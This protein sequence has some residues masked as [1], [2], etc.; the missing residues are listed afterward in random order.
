M[1]LLVE[2]VK[3]IG[4]ALIVVFI[5]KE[6]LVKLLRK[7]AE[8]LD[9][10]PKAVGNIA[11]VA[12][13]MPELLTV[14]FSSLQGLLSTSIYNIFSSNLINVVQYWV[15]VMLNKN[16]KEL[17]NR[18]I[19]TELILVFITILIPAVMVMFEFETNII[20]VPV[21]ICAFALFYKVRANAYKVYNT[22]EIR[23]EEVKK[24]TEE[25]RWI[26]HK[27]K[28]EVI[29]IIQL[30]L[31][32]CALFLIGNLLGDSLE[33]LCRDFNVPQYIVG[34]I[35]G[36]VTSIPELITFVESQKYHGKLNGDLE[37]VIEATGNLFA[38][39]TLNLFVIESIG[40]ITYTIVTIL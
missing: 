7:I 22:K 20:I 39:N 14:F 17:R 21:F 32:G 26:K 35:L 4:L 19:K 27:K 2:I 24:I 1:D 8:I 33:I 15:S 6:I 34:V 29:T 12:T 31:V 11:G 40:I 10:T 13:S 28:K 18:A 30:A 9:L 16:Q 5:S 3:C 38:S 36:I 23:S 37:G 25:K